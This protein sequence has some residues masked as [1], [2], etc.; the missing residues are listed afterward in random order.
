MV[1]EEDVAGTHEGW[2]IIIKSGAKPKFESL[3]IS[4]WSIANI[5]IL[6]KLLS[7]GKLDEQG[8]VDYLS[9]TT[10]IYQLTQRYE[11]VSVYFCD[12]EY[13]KMQACH[14]CRWGTD[15]PHWQTMQLT[16][17]ASRNNG[18]PTPPGKQT[19][20]AGPV[21][22]DGKPICKLYN[23]HRGCGLH[24]LQICACMFIQ[25]LWADSLVHYP[26]TG[27]VICLSEVGYPHSGPHARPKSRG[28]TT[29]KVI[30][31]RTFCWKV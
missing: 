15:V 10:K 20:R 9:Y 13:R 21:T 6:Y 23:T 11:N 25:G 1:E 8:M 22:T 30:L 17:R 19:L 16:P 26:L 7:E 18:R 31:T 24:G 4:Q 2:Q 29:Y 28:V 27:S 14:K 5:A 3:T 12:R